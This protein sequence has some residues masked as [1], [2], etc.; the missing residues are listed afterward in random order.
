V[1][2]LDREE[3]TDPLVDD[4][5]NF[6]KVEKWTRDGTKV[7]SL[8]Y[9]GN[10]RGG[11]RFPAL[12]R[13]RSPAQPLAVTMQRNAFHVRHVTPSH[14]AVTRYRRPCNALLGRRTVARLDHPGRVVVEPVG[15]AP[16]APHHDVLLDPP[17]IERRRFPPPRTIGDNGACYIIRDKNGQ[18]LSYVY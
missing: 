3:T 2:D 15:Q 11:N 8:L 17:M 16:H 1:P 18:A 4:V 10:S 13:S 14:T 9:A 12:T 7:D 5:R 6:Y